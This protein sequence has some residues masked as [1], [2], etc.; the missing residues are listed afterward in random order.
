MRCFNPRVAAVT[1]LGNEAKQLAM[2]SQG[3]SGLAL[4]RLEKRLGDCEQR[5]SQQTQRLA[6]LE[7]ELFRLDGRRS[8]TSWAMGMLKDFGKLWPVLNVEMRCRLLRVLL[9]R[10][11]VDTQQGRVVTVL[12][13]LGSALAPSLAP[14]A[15]E[16]TP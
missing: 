1:R 14:H 2:D 15:Q 9:E 13:D 8:D 11:E 5:Q 12:A 6:D 4:E 3:L 7:A 10:V 16:A